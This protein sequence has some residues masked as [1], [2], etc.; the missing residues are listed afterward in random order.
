MI[1]YLLRELIS[2]FGAG[3]RSV[4]AYLTRGILNVWTKMRQATQI[5]R[6]TT[7]VMSKATKNVSQVG[8]KPEH[9][10]DFVETKRLFISKAFIFRAVFALILI[11]AI[12]YFVLY[13]LVMRYFFTARMNTRNN[14]LPTYTGKVIVYYDEK[15]T[16]PFYEGYLKEGLL[17]GSGKQYDTDGTLVYDGEFL[18]GKR[19]G[20]GDEYVDGE[21][22]YRGE[23]ASGVYEGKGEQYQNGQLIR[24]GTYSNGKLDGSD[25]SLYYSNGRLA[26]RGAFTAG[27]QTGEGIAY[28]ESGVQ[29]YS[30]SFQ[31]GV[32]QGSGTAY[33]ENG[34]PCYSG[35]FKNNRYEGDGTL[36]MA[37]NF[38]LEGGFLQ[39]AQAG[40]AVISHNGIVY[41]DGSA[42]N[43]IPN[44]Q[45]TIY[46][47]L[48]N[49][50]FSGTMRS[51]VIDG[52][53]LLGKSLDAVTAALGDVLLTTEEK[54]GGILLTSEELGLS[55]YFSY[56]RGLE[57]A[58]S[59]F[60]VFFYRVPGGD[61]ALQSVLWGFADDIDAWRSG[62]WN[63]PNIV[64]GMAVPQLAAQAYGD[65]SYPC[66]IY[67]DG[68]ASCT[69]WSDGGETFGVQ[70]TVAGG[71]TVMPKPAAE[72]APKADLIGSAAA[73]SD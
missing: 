63:N 7:R 25:C 42:V 66:A 1:G 48:G 5:A 43:S 45:G 36:Y 13:P 19:S 24:S 23:F 2:G 32:R 71:K 49:V 10:S 37:D 46:N 26:Y 4:K 68:Y 17:Q 69:I 65:K 44:G 57:A 38:R 6:G 72:I 59:S 53:A 64:A 20:T 52:R 61:S 15:K 31:R 21:L 18:D 41:Y 62:M 55:V 27:E 35:E 56:V 14:R 50:L 58:P 51:G 30:G 29:S 40:N 9:R 3:M 22:V 47:N 73:A 11:I 60:D 39:G 54:D 67:P 12:S 33:D 28:D 34:E 70:W 16:I 8:Q